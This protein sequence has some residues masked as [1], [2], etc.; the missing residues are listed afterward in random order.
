MVQQWN[1]Q[2]S[3]S[4]SIGT[5]DRL[6]EAHASS[7]IETVGRS[8]PI[9]TYFKRSA[10]RELFPSMNCYFSLLEFVT[11]C[12]F[13]L[14]VSWN[15][16]IN[17]FFFI[18]SQSSKRIFDAWSPR[19]ERLAAEVLSDSQQLSERRRPERIPADS[20]APCAHS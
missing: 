1:S 12:F 18:F 5:I 19:G 16:E 6:W 15:Q 20:Q 3:G 14:C 10:A 4:S 2:R 13:G 17:F 11:Q 8:R 9:K 7:S